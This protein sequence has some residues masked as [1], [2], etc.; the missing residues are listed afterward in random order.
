M[1]A[2]TKNCLI[3]TNPP[4][5]ERIVSEDLFVLYASLGSLFKHRFAGS[6]AWVISSHKE[7]LAQ[8]GL[9]PSRKIRLLNGAL[10]CSYNRYDLFAGKHKQHMASR[11]SGE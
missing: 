10:D 1:E 7:C 2:P 5:G 3:V 6:T 9:K 8:I 11:P 4:Y